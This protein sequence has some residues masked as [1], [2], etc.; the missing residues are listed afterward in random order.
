MAMSIISLAT[1]IG[2]FVLIKDLRSSIHGK[3]VLGYALSLF[4]YL[5]LYKFDDDNIFLFLA[6]N[7]GFIG[8]EATEYWNLVM[9]FDICWS[10]FTM[11]RTNESSKRFW[12]YG[13][14]VAVPSLVTFTIWIWFWIDRRFPRWYYSFKEY[15][16]DSVPWATVIFLVIAAFKAYR[17]SKTLSRSESSRFKDEMTR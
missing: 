16:G 15:F 17:M 9:A 14:F 4:C 7:I 11:M 10:L 6:H 1:F 12:F 2:T 3:L 8:L 5:A 13:S